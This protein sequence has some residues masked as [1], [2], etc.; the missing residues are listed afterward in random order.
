MVDSLPGSLLGGSPG[1]KL[2]RMIFGLPLEAKILPRGILLA[3]V[4]VGVPVEGIEI[5]TSFSA[6]SWIFGRMTEV[7]KHRGASGTNSQ[8]IA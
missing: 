1:I 5:V 2:T 6:T 4:L 3:P 7:S 8:K